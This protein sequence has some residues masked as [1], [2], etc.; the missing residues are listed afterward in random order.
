MS[1]PLIKLNNAGVSRNGAWLVRNIDLE[2]WRGEIITLIG[3]NG[4]GKSTTAKMALKILK[5]TEGTVL[6]APH[7]RVGYVPQKLH[8][9]QTM[10]ISVARFMEL[11]YPLKK[12][13]IDD[14]LSEVGALHLRS[15]QVLNLSGGELQRV[16]LARAA[17][18]KP[19]VLV[20]DEPLQGIDFTGEAEL[21]ELISH[22]RKRLNCGILLI[23]HDL[24]VVM[25]ASDKVLC[26]NGHICCS[27]KPE[28]VAMSEQYNAL[29]SRNGKNVAALYHHNHDH[30]H[31]ID[32]TICQSGNCHHHNPTNLKIQK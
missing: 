13:V 5:P 31:H 19:D 10:P 24:H 9:D 21:Y 25:A 6:Q 30:N 32:G 1:L 15:A 3:P 18:R 4:S 17:A 7:L 28:E 29:F 23:S 12:Q 2:L 20:L 22:Y 11:T 14:A 16:M 26:L 8:F 27:G